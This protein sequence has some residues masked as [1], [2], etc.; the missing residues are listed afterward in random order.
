M[1]IRDAAKFYLHTYFLCDFIPIIPLLWWET[2]PNVYF[3]K[4]LRVARLRRMIIFFDHMEN[5]MVYYFFQ[6]INELRMTILGRI[7]KIIQFMVIY[8]FV[9]HLFSCVLY[10]IGYQETIKGVS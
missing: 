8:Y 1:Y 10:Y 4:I 6:N 3:M 9:F 2:E 5:L 7:F